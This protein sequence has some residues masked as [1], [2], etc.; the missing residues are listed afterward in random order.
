ML[1]L[2]GFQLLLSGTQLR[3]LY[4]TADKS[5]VNADL[6][7]AANILRKV[8]GNLGIDLSRLGRRSL[9][10]VGRIRIWLTRHC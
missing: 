3:G 2:V 8:A 5:K 7:A 9:A 6:N 10:T 4:T 1:I